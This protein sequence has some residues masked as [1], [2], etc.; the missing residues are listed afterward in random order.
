[1]SSENSCCGG[2]TEIEKKAVDADQTLVMGVAPK[3]KSIDEGTEITGGSEGCKC[4]SN[5]SCNPCKC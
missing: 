3:T 4:G 1:M 5:C 2:N